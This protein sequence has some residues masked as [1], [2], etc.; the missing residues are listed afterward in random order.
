MNRIII[1]KIVDGSKNSRDADFK[2]IIWGKTSECINFWDYAIE[3]LFR[4]L[5]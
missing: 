1:R 4:I 5:C 2:E 3:W